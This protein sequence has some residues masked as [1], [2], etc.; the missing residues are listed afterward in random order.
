M[1]PS[2]AAA[3]QEYFSPTPCV[4]F[5]SLSTHALLEPR[6]ENQKSYTLQQATEI[7]SILQA[8]MP[9]QATTKA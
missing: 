9:S 1:T 8:F 3:W 6:L 4:N 7:H 2:S 5:S